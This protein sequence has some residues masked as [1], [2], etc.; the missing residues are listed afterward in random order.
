MEPL[1]LDVAFCLMRAFSGA[2]LKCCL[3]LPKV[4]LVA[5]VAEIVEEYARVVNHGVDYID[6]VMF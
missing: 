5:P 4:V 3:Q 2:A 6:D 1:I